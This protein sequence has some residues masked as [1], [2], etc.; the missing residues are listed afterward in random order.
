MGPSKYKR[1][2]LKLS[3]EAMAGDRGV[4][5]DTPTISIIAQKIKEVHD[6]G[7]ETSIVVGGGNFWRGRDSKDM[8]RTTSDYMGMLGT[9]MNALALQ[10][11]LE[12]MGVDTRVQTAIEMKEVAEPYIRRR[13]I[14]HLEKGRVVIFSGGIGNPYFS[15]DTTAALRA[16]EIDADV[17]LLA[18]KGVDGI[19]DSDPKLNPNA[20]KFNHLSY[21]EILSKE[22][23][24]MDATATSLCMD[25]SI[26][27]IVF[28]IDNSQNIVDVVMGEEI[29]TNVK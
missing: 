1:I 19:Y 12:E 23:K 10:D 26:P 25:N 18:K 6:H 8:D 27:L 11:A 21:Y 20:I 24:I 28:G 5:I 2:V 17:I 3:G 16:A 29:G 4:G 14:R 15:T 13:A 22:L 9:V 7:V